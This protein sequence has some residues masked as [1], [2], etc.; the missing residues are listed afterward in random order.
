MAPGTGNGSMPGSCRIP[1]TLVTVRGLPG[2]HPHNLEKRSH[3]INAHQ[4]LVRT[5]LSMYNRDEKRVL[6]VVASLA[7]F[8]VPYTV[9]SLSIALPAIGEAF[10]LDAVTLG[11]VTSAYLLTA[12]VCIVPFG[13]ISDMYGRK[14][15]S[16]SLGIFYSA[17]GR[18]LRPHHGPA[19]LSS[20]PGLS[21][22]WEDRWY[23]PHRLPSSHR[24]FHQG[25]GAGLSGL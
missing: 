24:S 6:L 12:T 3:T 10:T 20:S 11:W 25:S 1:F 5:F 17:P 23:S 2:R 22:R 8:L 4:G 16:L 19:W 18:C 7:S 15:R 13:S 21:R 9:S 14:K